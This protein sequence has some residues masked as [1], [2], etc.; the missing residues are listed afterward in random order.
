MHLLACIFSHKFKSRLGILNRHSIRNIVKG[1]ARLCVALNVETQ[2]LQLLNDKMGLWRGT[3]P[4]HTLAV[5]QFLK[6]QMA[7]VGSLSYHHPTL[8]NDRYSYIPFSLIAN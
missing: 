3:M 7:H 8:H 5:A 4:L 2:L 1:I 6:K